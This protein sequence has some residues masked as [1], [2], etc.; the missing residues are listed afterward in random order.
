[1]T[2]E[3]QHY[4]LGGLGV[5]FKTAREVMRLTQKDVATRLHLSPHLIQLIESEDLRQA[6]PATFMRGYL[7]SY[8]KLLNITEEEINLA[9]SQTSFDIPSKMVITPKILPVTDSI[10][11]SDRYVHWITLLVLSVSLILA[12]IWWSSHPRNTAAIVPPPVAPV[13]VQP[14]VVA[15]PPPSVPAPVIAPTAQ[16]APIVATPTPQPPAPPAAPVTPPAAVATSPML[17]ESELPPAPGA[18][19][20]TAVPSAD[21]TQPTEEQPRKK[22]IRRHSQDGRVSGMQMALPEPGL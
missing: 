10:Q 8:A 16:Q 7:R 21:G 11:K 4:P 5:R 9:L 14:V 6:P 15:T 19:L 13:A 18:E 22:R 3:N 17:P 2:E 12:A 1:M 20:T